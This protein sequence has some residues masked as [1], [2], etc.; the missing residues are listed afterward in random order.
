MEDANLQPAPPSATSPAELFPQE[1]P[2]RCRLPAP[3]RV[4]QTQLFSPHSLGT[5]A[6][7]GTGLRCPAVEADLPSGDGPDVPARALKGLSSSLG[8]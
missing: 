7:V 2:E 3:R 4:Q 6:V 8:A 1:H 5:R